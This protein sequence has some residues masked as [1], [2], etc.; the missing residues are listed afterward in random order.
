M[1]EIRRQQETA[2]D[3][4]REGRAI[5]KNDSISLQEDEAQEL[6]S[7]ISFVNEKLQ[8]LRDHI[9]QRC[10]QL[11]THNYILQA[12]LAK[13][14]LEASSSGYVSHKTCASNGCISQ[15]TVLNSQ[16]GFPG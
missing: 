5:L 9:T 14:K 3:V 2:V 10:V 16:K 11:W 13:P 7:E 6:H 1:Q 8:E 12:F 15:N 4:L